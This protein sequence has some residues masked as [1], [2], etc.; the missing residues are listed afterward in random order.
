MVRSI[1]SPKASYDD[2]ADVFYLTLAT[3]KIGR[4]HEDER[5]LVWRYSK[6]GKAIGVTVQGYA[7]LWRGQ[8]RALATVIGHELHLDPVDVVKTFPVNLPDWLPEP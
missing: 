1:S 4:Y 7:H 3:E 5:G 6:S 2:L 8:Q